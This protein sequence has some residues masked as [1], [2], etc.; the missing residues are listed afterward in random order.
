MIASFVIPTPPSNAATTS[1]SS[2]VGGV[3]ARARMPESA[4]EKQVESAAA[5]S[6]S[7]L[8][9]AEASS[10]RAR[11]VTFCGPVTP[12]PSVNTPD[13]LWRSP[14]HVVC[15]LCSTAMLVPLRL[16]A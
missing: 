3:L 6:S 8:V 14:S 13:P 11:H 9:P 7:G 12:L 5:I 15:A 2:L 16:F 4:I 10:A 1:V